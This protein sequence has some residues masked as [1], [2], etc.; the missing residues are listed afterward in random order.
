[1]K[2]VSVL[3]FCF[4]V[5]IV[6]AGPGVGTNS[7]GQ[8]VYK[9]TAYQQSFSIKYEVSKLNGAA[10]PVLQKVRSD[11][12][13]VIQ[14]YSS[15][16]LLTVSGG[17]FLY[18]GQ[19]VKDVSYQ[20]MLNKKI[21][22]IGIYQNQ[23]VYLDDKAVLSNAWAGSLYNRHT[24]PGASLF[25]GGDGFAFLISDGITSQYVKDSKVIWEGKS[26]EKIIDI[27]FDSLRN[28]FWLL[29][30]NAIS[31]FSPQNKSIAAK[32]TGKGLT[33]FAL[34]KKNTQVVAGTHN[35]YFTINANT[36]NASVEVKKLLPCPDITVVKEINDKLWFGSVNGAF[37][38]QADGKYKYYASKRSMPS[39][40]VVDIAA[41]E[42]GNV[43]ILT[44]KGIGEIH[45]KPMTLHEKAMYY[46]Q[47]VRKRHIRL[48]FNATISR[49][50][51]GDVSTGSLED[52]DNDGLW[53]SMY[54]GAE[55]FR[56]AA[57]KSPEALENC[58]ESL[59]AMERLYTVNSLKGFPSRSY[60][61][62]GYAIADTQVWKH[63]ENPEWDWKS[64]TSSDEAIGHIFVFAAI[65]ELI[66]DSAMKNKAIRLIDAL[67]THVVEHD[68]YM[69]DWDGKPTRW[70]RWNPAYVNAR[71][72][73]VGDRKINSSNII[74]MLQT[75]WHF[76]HKSIYKDKA[77][78]LMNKYGYLENLMR[79]MKDIGHAPDDADELSKEL[80]D[81]WNHSDDEMYFVGYWGLYRYAFNDTLKAKYKEAIID[82]WQAE[83]P[84]KEGAWNI[85][86]ALTGVR[87]F[88]LNEAI[89][90]L[91]KYPLDMI[92]W[93]VKNS[94]RKD[95]VTIPANFR[96]QTIT[97]VLPP[98]E[99]RIS[100]HNSN[101]FDLDGGSEQGTEEYSAGDIWLL[102]YWMGRYLQ[103]ISEPVEK[104]SPEKPVT[105]INASY[106]DVPF[107]QR[108]SIKYYSNDTAV[109]L[110]SVAADHNGNIQ[111]LSSKGLLK[112]RAGELLN[113]GTLVNDVAYV[114]IIKKK[115][116]ALTTYNNEFVY[117][118][119]KAVLSNAWA[120]TLYVQHLLP[121]ANIVAAGN[122][123]F[124]L[125]AGGKHI[126]LLQGNIVAWSGEAADSIVSVQFSRNENL[127]WLL[128]SKGVFSLSPLK[129]E[130]ANVFM[131]DGLTCFKLLPGRILIGT[132]NGYMQLNAPAYI[133]GAVN[134]S[135][136]CAD[137]SVIE[138]IDGSIWFGSPK[139]AFMLKG[140]GGF[141]YYASER[142]LP[143]DGVTAITRGSD[144]SI[145]ILTT[146][147]LAKICADKITLDEKAAYYENI[148][149]KRH[150]R[151]GFYS[152]Y[153]N[154][155]KG[156]TAAVTMGPHDS[157][158]L[159][160]SMYLTA[161]MFRYLV[162]HEED[163]RQNC[164]E[165]L[166][167]MER[168]FT[169]SGIE[170]LFGRCIERA[171]MVSFHDEIRP[172]EKYYWYPGYDH[173]PSS[174]HHTEGGEWDWRGS[175]SSDQAVGQYFALT[176]VAQYMDDASLKQKAV[177]LIDKLTGYIV[178]NNLTLVDVDGKP[179]LWGRWNPEHI[180]R[181]PDMV[182]DKKLYSSN[183]IAFLQTAWHFTG[184]QQY[185]AIA[186][187]LLYKQHYLDNL[188]RP[189]SEIGPAPATADKWSQVLSGG[190]NSSDDE[191][192]FLAYWGLYPYALDAK[193]RLQYG[194]AIH[195]HWNIIR[196]E[197]EAL[198]NI[199]YA[200]ITGA[201]DFDLNESIWELQRMP[202]DLCNWRIHNSGRKDLDFVQND[203]MNWP[204]KNVLPPDE[205]PENKHNRNLF[206]L[207]D[208]G[209]GQ[210]EL[211]GGDVYL[212]PYW[213]ARY[214]GKISAPANRA[215]TAIN[216]AIL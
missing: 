102:P 1:M 215:K 188:A 99:L 53:T 5:V 19:L 85:F 90:Y 9:D 74:A 80:S 201:K 164:S 145:L 156:D 141:D 108:Y 162:T 189:V 59:D 63:A 111:V 148:V 98:D 157:D 65:A 86:T 190:W 50:K 196:P 131:G 133:A 198:W 32:Y 56:Y 38:L 169:L 24:M 159:W 187:D 84:E 110:R 68:L 13:G 155:R 140:D 216:G 47:Q 213:M 60:E 119:D 41:G 100:R 37:M 92:D 101:R 203:K 57:T 183:I 93:K 185:R 106:R 64:T 214:F 46:E 70:G 160:T 10:A 116:N 78:E 180:N 205:R 82:H 128:S 127:F 174:W 153:T 206:K 118:D 200:A 23:F 87:N 163:A 79:P 20:P 39:D 51:D 4:V 202:L 195:D 96:R 173:T 146:K 72:K 76:T 45:F 107:T 88:D 191:M 25:C 66:D 94:Q 2:V 21:S 11:R 161:E 27:A 181:F 167:A 152:D 97:E 69:I 17:Q 33:C 114:S 42:N 105:V 176:M 171:G 35:G 182:G 58:R 192:Y 77:F 179:T 193:L 177:K 52:S 36:G 135:L 123:G 172:E 104:K 166:A 204:V 43:L 154:V 62:R 8:P 22:N 165:S 115:I 210:A 134:N 121:G 178:A 67:M 168:L 103:I 31:V 75:A 15:A 18:P 150:I 95:I 129:K 28:I 16:G 34:V 71:P 199:C 113:S 30:E 132:H 61:R 12:N 143:S 186:E 6:K 208:N 126:S 83:R 124:F 120:G 147:G 26:A 112:P 136:P 138:E 54:L 194:K 209:T 158:N 29:S 137:I 89:W 130:L 175:A 48:G 149:R 125:V 73:I 184:K 144:S 142:W 81:G 49:M 197:K 207:D 212:L 117:A 7:K 14:V 122:N 91:Q 109:S 55:V 40:M 211:G 170:G 44:D 151:Y 139:G 3:A